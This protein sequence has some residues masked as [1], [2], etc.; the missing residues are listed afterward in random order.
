MGTL[1]RTKLP[2]P[3]LHETLYE[4]PDFAKARE[5]TVR[6]RTTIGLLAGGMSLEAFAGMV[7]I[8]LAIVGL[9]GHVSFY[10]TAVATLAIGLA[11]MSQGLALAAR[12]R[13]TVERL[14]GGRRE[15]TEV[16]GGVGAELIG[17]AI[18]IVLAILALADV[19]PLVLLPAAAVVFG[20]AMLL[21]SPAQPEIGRLAIDRDRRLE[22]L[23]RE[24]LRA[25]A[26]AMAFVGI[27][28]VVLGL[29]GLTHAAS[30]LVLSLVALLLLGGTALLSGGALAAKFARRLQVRV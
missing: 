22:K 7:A 19:Y 30:E 9:A 14:A 2:D 3:R 24:A 15:S 16:G 1:R 23:E 12:W 26:G 20:G 18:G 17:G 10:M 25:S 28:A 27:A 11:L 4:H 5:V 29:L 21:G 13:D 8:V 6:S